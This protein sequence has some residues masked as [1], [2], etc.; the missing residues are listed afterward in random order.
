[1]AH[2]YS[3]AYGFDED[4]AVYSF[5]TLQ[6]NDIAG[7]LDDGGFDALN[8]E[9]FG[10]VEPGSGTDKLGESLRSVACIA[11][12]PCSSSHHACSPRRYR[13]LNVARAR[14]HLLTRTSLLFRQRFRFCRLNRSSSRRRLETGRLVM[15]LWTCVVDDASRKRPLTSSFALERAQLGS[16]AVRCATA[17]PVARPATVPSAAGD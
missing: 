4:V 13:L 10:D 14:G 16:I 11:P 15:D 1:M 17:P 3:D 5:D 2:A 7:L 9:T 12:T 6:D 8:D